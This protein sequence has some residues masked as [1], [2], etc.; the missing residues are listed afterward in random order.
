[1]HDGRRSSSG[2]EPSGSERMKKLGEKQWRR[3]GGAAAARLDLGKQ[4]ALEL[5]RQ[6]KFFAKC[7]KRS[8]EALEALYSPR[9][10]RGRGIMCAHDP[11]NCRDTRGHCPKIFA[12]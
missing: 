12:T 11:R 8:T 2:G 9:G 5:K 6:R 4:R 10:D 3:G 7:W 1:V